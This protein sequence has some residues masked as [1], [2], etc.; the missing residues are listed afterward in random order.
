MRGGI[1]KYIA[2]LTI[3]GCAAVFLHLKRKL[4][5]EPL[6]DLSDEDW[7]AGDSYLSGQV[8]S[9]NSLLTDPAVTA[10]SVR[11]D[12]FSFDSL[13]GEQHGRP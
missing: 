6:G 10:C 8:T 4:F 13:H 5:N 3:F 12:G 1:H 11:R 7:L 9:P 2:A